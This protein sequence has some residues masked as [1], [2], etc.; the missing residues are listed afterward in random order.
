M[1]INYRLVKKAK[2]YFKQRGLSDQ[3]IQFW[4][5]GYA[6]EDWQHLEKS[7]PL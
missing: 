3:T 1:N 5:L 6:P 2:N 4:R 7:F